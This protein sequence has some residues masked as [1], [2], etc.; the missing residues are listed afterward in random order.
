MLTAAHDIIYN[1]SE[2]GDD[3]SEYILLFFNAE[4]IQS[5]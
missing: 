3:V 5:T 4:T 1:L 2:E